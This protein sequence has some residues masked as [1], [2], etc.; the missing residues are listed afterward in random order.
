MQDNDSATYR[1]SSELNDSG[2]PPASDRKQPSTCASDGADSPSDR[3]ARVLT[4]L[5]ALCDLVPHLQ[6]G[7]SAPRVDEGDAAAA[8]RQL[9]QAAFEAGE[10]AAGGQAGVDA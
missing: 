3:L 10:R 4:T 8:L 7:A 5:Q 2:G 1:R 6:P 9:E